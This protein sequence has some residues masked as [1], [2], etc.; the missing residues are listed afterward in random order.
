M[1]FIPHLVSSTF[2]IVDYSSLPKQSGDTKQQVLDIVFALSA[3]IA[4]LM[5]V[6]SGFRY[7]VANGD[8]NATATAKKGILYA[9][10]GLIVV[11]AAYS[12]VAFVVNGVG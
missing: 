11:M 9:I 4:L 1:N 10:I 5:I 2:A 12:I 3:S 7:I 8:P 6:I